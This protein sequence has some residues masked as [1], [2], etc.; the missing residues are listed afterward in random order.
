MWTESSEQLQPQMKI[1]IIIYNHNRLLSMSLCAYLLPAYL[2]SPSLSSLFVARESETGCFEKQITGV[3]HTS[4]GL[5][6][7]C[8]H[9][10]SRFSLLPRSH[11]TPRLVLA[12]PWLGFSLLQIT[13]VDVQAPCPCPLLPRDPFTRD[14]CVADFHRGFGGPKWNGNGGH[15]FAGSPIP[16]LPIL[17]EWLSLLNELII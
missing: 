9:V 13:V 7:A 14:L 11:P 16:A 12:R 17:C 6:C 8:S 15:R 3:C 10:S 4:E 2:S 1:K 5:F